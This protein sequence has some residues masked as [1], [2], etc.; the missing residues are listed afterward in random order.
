MVDSIYAYKK[1]YSSIVAVRREINIL[2]MLSHPHIIQVYG[3]V[4]TSTE[5]Y[6]IMEYMEFGELFDYI[7]EKGRLQEDEARKFFQQVQI[8]IIEL[9][10]IDTSV[11]LINNNN[12]YYTQFIKEK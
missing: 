8:F 1:I 12:L 11:I 3:V 5:I 4:E 7:V 9:H 10:F 2:K 6:V